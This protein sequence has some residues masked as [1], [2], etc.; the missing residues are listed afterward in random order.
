MKASFH[1]RFAAAAVLVSIGSF[2]LLAGFPGAVGS[3][4]FATA[5]AKPRFEFHR[6]ISGRELW[7]MIGGLAVFIPLIVACDRLVPASIGDS[8]ARV[9]R[10]PAF[11]VPLWLL[12]L[13]GLRVR[14][15]RQREEYRDDQAGC[16]EPT[17][18]R[19]GTGD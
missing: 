8:V 10:H 18:P 14:W 15:Q 11:V 7:V 19:N 16:T 17:E 9:I 4:C 1:L 2:L 6:P 13:W 3:F 12:L 5:L